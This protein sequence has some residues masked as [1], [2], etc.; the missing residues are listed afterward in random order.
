MGKILIVNAVPVGS[1]GLTGIYTSDKDEALSEYAN[2]IAG[3]LMEYQIVAIYTIGLPE[4]TMMA[5]TIADKLNI[6]VQPM[7]GIDELKII[8]PVIDDLEVIREHIGRALDVIAEK[9]RKGIVAVI[10]SPALSVI[11]ILYLLHMHN[12]HFSQIVQDAG[13]INLFEVRSGVPSAL[14]INDTCHLHGLN[15]KIR[16]ES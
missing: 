4:V 5:N 8:I 9:Y 12:K 10:S 6:Q 11:M 13:A 7:P 3:R 15:L 14:F 2:A 16:Q 1:E